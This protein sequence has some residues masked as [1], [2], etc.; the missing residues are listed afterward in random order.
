[1]TA[2]RPLQRKGLDKHALMTALCEHI[3]NGESLRKACQHDGMPDKATVLRWMGGEGAEAKLLRDHYA[4]VKEESAEVYADEIV[5]I[6][7]E[8]PGRNELTGTVDAGAV[9]H[10][11]LRVDARKWVASKLKP[12]KYGDR[13]E[14][15]HSGGI[16]LTVA[17]ADRLAKARARAGG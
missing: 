2:K 14:I 13:Q 16:D 6:A 3:A 12:K 15:E 8:D 5:E 1:M 9:A 4:R 7:D 11:R 17:L 10:Q